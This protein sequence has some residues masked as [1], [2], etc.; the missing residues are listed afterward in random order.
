[1]F[2]FKCGDRV[3]IVPGTEYYW[4]APGIEGVVRDTY[5]G[6]PVWIPVN[7]D[8]GYRNAYP[9]DH[10]YLVVQESKEEV[11]VSEIQKFPSMAGTSAMYVGTEQ[12]RIRKSGD[13]L[14]I[15]I[16][17]E[18]VRVREAG[19]D[20]AE[21]YYAMDLSIADLTKAVATVIAEAG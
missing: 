15:H 2:K 10:L 5:D 21:D 13:N 11:A 20:I 7:F 12:F 14:R 6:N 19:G 16:P 18:Y 1:M 4:Q 8:N 9:P 17:A 3:A